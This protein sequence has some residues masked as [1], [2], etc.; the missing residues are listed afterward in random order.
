VRKT[1]DDFGKAHPGKD[2]KP[3]A[4]ISVSPGAIGGFGAN[5][6]IRQ[7]LET[8]VTLEQMREAWMAIS[9]PNYIERYAQLPK[10]TLFIYARYD[11]TF[12]FRFSEQVIAKARE[13]N[14]D[15]KAV[16]LPCVAPGGTFCSVLA[17]FPIPEVPDA[18]AFA[19]AVKPDGR[20]RR[21]G[22]FPEGLNPI[23]PI[24]KPT[25]RTGA[26]VPGLYVSDDTTG[27]TYMTPLAALARY[28][29]D[30]IVGDAVTSAWPAAASGCASFASPKSKSL[31]PDA[32][33]MTFPGFRSRCTIP[34]RWARSNASQI[35]SPN[36]SDCLTGSGPLASRA[37]RLSPWRYSITR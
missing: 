12:P 5:Q 3:A 20:T 28:A 18:T 14:M 8:V 29:G 7:S 27:Y 34:A 9:P 10:K 35:C 15:H 23:A 21:I 25:G 26:P 31:A 36:S 1:L 24:P 37:S 30:V 32:V 2:G 4:V 6:H 13:L 17:L 11:T 19:V 16:V 33:S 22:G